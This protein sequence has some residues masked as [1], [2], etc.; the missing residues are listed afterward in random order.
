MVTPVPPEMRVLGPDEVALK[1]VEQDAD[2]LPRSRV[3]RQGQPT[4]TVVD[5]VVL[6]AAVQWHDFLL[7]FVTDDIPYEDML[8]ISLLDAQ[9]RCLDHAVLGG[10]YSTG[11]FSLLQPREDSALGFRFMG[12]TDWHL[13]LCPGPRFRW[14]WF[15]EPRGVTRP[16]GFSR[17]FVI[18]GKPQPASAT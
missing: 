15:S 9:G 13:E 18:H 11:R 17:H 14:P 6:E 16:F 10:M 3:I 2:Q 7:L 8:R 1:P 4:A 12:D 5:G